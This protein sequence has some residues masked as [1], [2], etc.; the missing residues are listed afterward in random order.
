MKKIMNL[1]YEGFPIYIKDYE[2]EDN[3][4]KISLVNIGK[5]TVKKIQFKYRDEN[6][7]FDINNDEEDVTI[8]IDDINQ[9][10]IDN[11]ELEYVETNKQIYYLKDF[12]KKVKVVKPKSV[13]FLGREKY[14]YIHDFC[15][16]NKINKQVF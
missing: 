12:K 6:V 2:I 10:I 15:K 11:I 7:Q 5:E 9:D 3:K 4:F 14:L 1:Y 8:Y 13:S 16:L